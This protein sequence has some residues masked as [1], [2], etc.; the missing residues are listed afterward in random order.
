ME[1][2][3]GPDF[4]FELESVRSLGEREKMLAWA[5][6][7]FAEPRVAD[8]A[9]DVRLY[10]ATRL[11]KELET[12]LYNNFQSRDSELGMGLVNWRK[13]DLAEVISVVRAAVA[14]R[15]LTISLTR[16]RIDAIEK[17]NQSEPNPHLRYSNNVI[18]DLHAEVERA[19]QELSYLRARISQMHALEHLLRVLYTD[20]QQSASRSTEQL[21]RLLA[22]SWRGFLRVSAFTDQFRNDDAKKLRN[23]PVYDFN[24]D[25]RGHL[26]KLGVNAKP[27][28]I[29]HNTARY[30]IHLLETIDALA[31]EAA[32]VMA[33]PEL[34]NSSGWYPIATLIR[35]II[36]FFHFC[37]FEMPLFY[38]DVAVDIDDPGHVYRRDTMG[39]S[40]IGEDVGVG[41]T[42]KRVAAEAA[43]L[44]VESTSLLECTDMDRLDKLLKY[45]A[46][47]APKIEQVEGRDV[48]P[49]ISCG[50]SEFDMDPAGQKVKFRTA[51]PLMSSLLNL[52]VDEQKNLVRVRG[53]ALGGPLDTIIGMALLEPNAFGLTNNNINQLDR[54]R[55]L[56]QFWRAVGRRRAI[57]MMGEEYVQSVT[58]G[59]QALGQPGP[60]HPTFLTL[61]LPAVV[62]GKEQ[63]LSAMGASAAERDALPGLV[64]ADQMRIIDL[65]NI[66]WALADDFLLSLRDMVTD[67]D[68]YEAVRSF[69]RMVDSYR[70]E[71]VKR[72]NDK[73]VTS[74]NWIWSMVRGLSPMLW[75]FWSKVGSDR[76]WDEMIT[77][78]PA[79][80][81]MGLLLRLFCDTVR[82]VLL[83]E[84]SGSAV[85]GG[86][87]VSAESASQ[88]VM[89][90]IERL[91]VGQAMPAVI[92]ESTDYYFD[93]EIQFDSWLSF[94]SSYKTYLRQ[95]I[96]DLKRMNAAVEHWQ[97]LESV[98]NE[99]ER[100]Y[101]TRVVA[102]PPPKPR[103]TKEYA[104]GFLDEPSTPADNLRIIGET[105]AAAFYKVCFELLGATDNDGSLFLRMLSMFRRIETHDWIYEG[106][107]HK[108]IIEQLLPDYRYRRLLYS[109]P[110]RAESF[111]RLLDKLE[112]DGRTSHVALEPM[113]PQVL[114]YFDQLNEAYIETIARFAACPRVL[115]RESIDEL[116]TRFQSRNEREHSGHPFLLLQACDQL[117]VYLD[118]WAED[119]EYDEQSA[120]TRVRETLTRSLGADIDDPLVEIFAL[121]GGKIAVGSGRAC[122]YGSSRMCEPAFIE[123]DKP[124]SRLLLSKF[125]SNKFALAL[126]V[127]RMQFPKQ[128]FIVQP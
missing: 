117:I 110:S 27:V 87:R 45:E 96:E 119:E 80:A 69:P 20:G 9:L 120:I 56:S 95:S 71:L 5:E 128:T 102:S 52:L 12:E 75:D 41:S 104:I 11:T 74:M 57:A 124:I 36:E 21:L 121:G 39:W 103:Q 46:S 28:V 64:M 123:P 10:D 94:V 68:L 30:L 37:N 127:L 25:I 125:V 33:R 78:A 3:S 99:L 38:L 122:L 8:Q 17:I 49:F 44:L 93:P 107:R 61:K 18:D 24:N 70:G 63:M 40:T 73:W 88:T 1:N 100:L 67:Q 48:Q 114:D 108:Q 51:F 55:F 4:I 113:R 29:N 85:A 116:T 19:T 65:I 83:L 23:L 101:P 54:F 47:T 35:S 43:L 82:L 58:A 31:V 6:R 60:E 86:L 97:L 126:D 109:L 111:F 84:T 89:L 26:L 79:A 13:T 42:L 53:S 66:T 14:K 118:A 98:L 62:V 115:P 16:T 50:L 72:F 32:D 91:Y 105:D 76:A 77:R 15:Y 106:A 34:L 22:Q 112:K 7:V 90:G 2:P 59:L 81:A 92:S